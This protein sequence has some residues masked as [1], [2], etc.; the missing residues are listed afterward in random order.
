MPQLKEA[1]RTVYLVNPRT[2]SIKLAIAGKSLGV[3]TGLGVV[4]SMAERVTKQAGFGREVNIKVVEEDLGQ[5][6]DPRSGDLVLAS[7]FSLTSKRVKTL[8]REANDKGAFVVVGGIHATKVPDDFAKEGAISFRGEAGNSAVFSDLMNQWLHK[9]GLKR[10]TIVESEGFTNPKAI[11]LA[12]LP[13]SEVVYRQLDNNRYIL[14]TFAVA[15]CPYDCDFC[16]VMGGRVVRTRPIGEV[17]DEIKSRRLDKKGFVFSDSNLAAAPEDYLYGLLEALASLKIPKAWAPEL[18]INLL[19][20]GGEKL[21]DALKAAHCQRLYIG[22][23]SP[24]A[25]NLEK[26]GKRQNLQYADSGKA[27]EIVEMVHKRGIKITGLFIAGFPTDTVES[28]R[29]IEPFIKETKVD[30]VVI[31]ILTPLPGSKIWEQ[32]VRDGLFDLQTLDTDKLDTRHLLF[33]H[34]LGNDVLLQEYKRLCSRVFATQ[35]VLSRSTRALLMSLQ[36][37]VPES[38]ERKIRNSL[39]AGFLQRDLHKGGKMLQR[40]ESIYNIGSRLARQRN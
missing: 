23:E 14:S 21:C 22:F 6:C 31:S 15:G 39:V 2:P 19:D 33:K 17:I 30:D 40:F 38:L 4:G 5:V 36:H 13:V 11:N 25:T 32:F 24:N 20:R 12:G 26:V 3:P 7:S 8:T 1:E 29:A 35:T 37:N 9:G 28:I 27:K 18:S 16:T 10:G 34:P